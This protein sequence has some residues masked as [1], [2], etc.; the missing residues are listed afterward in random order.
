MQKTQLPINILHRYSLFMIAAHSNY[1]VILFFILQST[2]TSPKD[3]AAAA[4]TPDTVSGETHL[5]RLLSWVS[6]MEC[7]L[8]V[9]V[10]LGRQV[11]LGWGRGC[12]AGA[13]LPRGLSLPGCSARRGAGAGH[14]GGWWAV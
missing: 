13:L 6:S 1:K 3:F 10:T 9:C 4:Q 2:S 11:Q 8:G 7:S 5:K 12:A 14:A